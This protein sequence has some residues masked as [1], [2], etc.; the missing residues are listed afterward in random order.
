MPDGHA[1]DERV[2]FVAVKNLRHQSH[3][4]MLAELPAV[5]GD[6]ARAF[7]AALWGATEITMRPCVS[8][9]NRASRRTAGR[10][11]CP[12]GCAPVVWDGPGDRLEVC[13]TKPKSTSA[14]ISRGV[15]RAMSWEIQ[16]SASATVRP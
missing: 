15:S 12:F 13:P 11:S 7:L 2:K 4:D 9:N 3:A 14:P 6:D 10:A 5:A 1:A 8:P 16:H